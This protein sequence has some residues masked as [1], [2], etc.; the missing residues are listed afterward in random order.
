MSDNKLDFEKNL[1][2]LEEV[3]EKLE[4]G[5]CSLEESIDLFEKGIK[6]TKQC[7]TAL[8]NA[9]KRITELSSLEGSE[10]NA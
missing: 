2:E 9:Q 7:R 1:G 8:D 3:I 4:N 6:Y 5:E 10:N